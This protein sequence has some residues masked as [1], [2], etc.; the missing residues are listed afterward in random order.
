LCERRFERVELL[1]LYL[2]G[3]IFGE[4]HVLVAVAWTR[5]ATSMCWAWPEGASENQVVVRRLEDLIE[6]GV[7]PDWQYLFVIDG[8]KA[9]RATD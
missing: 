3:I 9:L 5:K 2:D 8:S 4:H 1:L 6:R 7:K